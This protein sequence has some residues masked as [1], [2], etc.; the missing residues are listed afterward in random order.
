MLLY[1]AIISYILSNIIALALLFTGKR[2]GTGWFRM[3]ASLHL[4]LGLVFLFSLFTNKEESP[5]YISFLIFFCSGIIAGGLALGTNTHIILKIYFGLYC[6]SVFVFLFSPSGLL[7]FL[8]TANF[9]AHDELI[10]VYQ[11]YFLEKQRS[12]FSSDTTGVQYKFIQKNGMF[13]KTISRDLSFHGKLDSIKVL[14]VED[15][16]SALVRGFTSSKSFVEDKIDSADMLID[17]NPQQKD[18]IE[19]RL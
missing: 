12:T 17:L 8:M 16:K 6:I 3:L 5:R 1:A 14:S 2:L 10:P 18:Q 15:G 9:A 11:N 19:R 13:H 7:N 4:I